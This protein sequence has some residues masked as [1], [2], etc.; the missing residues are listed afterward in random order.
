MRDFLGF[1]GLQEATGEPSS[2]SWV[3]ITL[4]GPVFK[5]ALFLFVGFNKSLGL[6]AVLMMLSA[7]LS[8]PILR[9]LIITMCFAPDIETF[10]LA[11][12]IIHYFEIV[13]IFICGSPVIMSSVNVDS[14]CAHGFTW[15]L[16]FTLVLPTK[17]LAHWIK[18]YYLWQ[19][20]N[21][22]SRNCVINIYLGAFPRAKS[23]SRKMIV[24]IRMNTLIWK[25]KTPAKPNSEPGKR[26]Y[27]LTP[28]FPCPHGV[29]FAWLVCPGGALHT[30]RLW[31][32]SQKSPKV[33]SERL[34][35][36][37]VYFL[38]FVSH[39]EKTKS[40]F[41]VPL[42]TCAKIDSPGLG[43]ATCTNVCRWKRRLWHTFGFHTGSDCGK[44]Y[45][46]KSAFYNDCTSLTGMWP[47]H[48][49]VKPFIFFVIF[50]CASSCSPFFLQFADWYDS[51]SEFND[52]DR[53]G[54]GQKK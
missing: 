37:L 26:L 36:R 19:K 18:E 49:G 16:E 27:Q 12:L 22:I 5:R 33:S 52:Q 14:G 46:E 50:K 4:G 53:V 23:E 32:F 54:C 40:T 29:L 47:R 43:W 7:H 39:C 10:W 17:V 20:L 6:S 1:M 3:F 51:G 38:P 8:R 30:S 45:F 2:K 48:L 25:P 11:T 35:E 31:A 44:M 13:V 15:R 24:Y 34:I 21:W 42:F 9:S 41:L 28:V